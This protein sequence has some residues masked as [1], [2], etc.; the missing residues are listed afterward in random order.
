MITLVKEIDMNK[1]KHCNGTGKILIGDC[2]GPMYGDCPHCLNPVPNPPKPP[3]CRTIKGGCCIPFLIMASL[4]I[5][6]V[7]E[8]LHLLV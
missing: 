5:I 8:L 2:M 6:G 4:P 1:C 7:Y 3:E